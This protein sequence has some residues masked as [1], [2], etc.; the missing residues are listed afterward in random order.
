MA[1][2]PVSNCQWVKVSRAA[3][4]GNARGPRKYTTFKSVLH[5]QNDRTFQHQG[6]FRPKKIW[7]KQ[8]ELHKATIPVHYILG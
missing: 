7:G 1:A 6:V 2:Y 5:A 3:W 8:R 4:A